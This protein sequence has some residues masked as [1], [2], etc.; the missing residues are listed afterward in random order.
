MLHSLSHYRTARFF[1]VLVAMAFWLS[2]TS[3]A[4]AQNK[5]EGRLPSYRLQPM[6]L[7]K[8]Q[9]FQEPDL[10]RELRVSKDSSV[11]LPLIGRV[12][13]KNR[14]LRE[15]EL[16]ITDLYKQDYLVNPQINITVLDYA[17]RTV[18]VLGAVNTPGSVLIP[19]ERE[20]VLLDAIARSGG[21]SRLANRGKVS[22]TRTLPDGRTEN[23]SVNVDVVMSGDGAHRWPLQSGDVIYVPERVL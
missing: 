22:L 5:A 17:Q 21:F 12:D 8:I 13:V 9:V 2:P 10:D 16:A 23:Y 20:L 7:I 18:N 3:L 14:S 15:V 19:P 1:S 11:V 4:Q 6:D